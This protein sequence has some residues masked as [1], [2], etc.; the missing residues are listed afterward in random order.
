[1]PAV[2]AGPRYA[3]QGPA[4]PRAARVRR[5][6]LPRADVT[7]W[8]PG[9]TIPAMILLM[10]TS[11]DY[12]L[13]IRDI[14]QSLSATPD[15]NSLAE[16]CVYLAVCFG[17]GRVVLAT[18]GHRTAAMPLMFFLW[19]YACYMAMTE[20]WAIYP[21][22]GAV[23]A[24][25]FIVTLLLVVVV[26]RFAGRLDLHRLAIA[27][28]ML[29]SCSVVFGMVFK[30]P[31][32]RLQQE[33]FNWLYVHPVIAGSYLA[34]GTIIIVW[35]LWCR[36]RDA[37]LVR[38][39]VLLLIVMLALTAG[40]LLATKTRGAIGGC[41]AG[42]GILAIMAFRRYRVA[43]F[44]AGVIAAFTALYFFIGPILAYLSRGEDAGE[45]TSFNGRTPLWSQAW[46]LFLDRPLTGYGVTASRGLFWNNVALGGAHNAMINVVVDGGLIGLVLWLAVIG[47]IVR[48]LPRLMKTAA[49]FT[50]APVLG[51]ILA[52]L[53][54][55]GVTTE[56]MGY[57]A[58]VNAIWFFVVAGWT[59][60]LVRLTTSTRR[61]PAP[62]ALVDH[63]AGS[64]VAIVTT[65]RPR[66]GD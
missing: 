32:L 8:R 25:Q 20:V 12:K 56:G 13:R 46:D 63:Y 52:C 43:T 40:G 3:D 59:A 28:A 2:A 35:L 30:F 29:V 62:R 38:A 44:G 66:V 55:D 7:L 61:P 1:M 23:R 10:L 41:V 37:A 22:L 18:R 34:I 9:V 65:P 5:W 50:D 45:I 15:L 54:L 64:P 39:P 58:N 27:Y 42:L 14:G 36:L 53:L 21:V 6:Q 31:R 24:W 47:Q 48:R 17:L 33:R 26:A 49:G 51:G 60:M 11:S 16:I 19:L 57:I 4:G